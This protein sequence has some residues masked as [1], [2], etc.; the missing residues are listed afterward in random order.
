M[1]YTKNTFTLYAVNIFSMQLI[2]L[3]R[4]IR[5]KNNYSQA[6]KHLQNKFAKKRVI[7][8]RIK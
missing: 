3:F 2:R 5:I 7:R 6:A 4:V 8:K 1:V